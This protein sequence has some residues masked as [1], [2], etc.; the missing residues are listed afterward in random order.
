MLTLK[1]IARI[2]HEANRAV[3]QN[4]GDDSQPIWDAAPEW[5][6]VSAE[7]G[8]KKVRDNPSITPEQL[9]QAW[10]DFKIADGWT[11]GDVKDAN[12]KAHPCLVPYDK[13]PE[14]QR[15]KDVVFRAICSALI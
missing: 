13:L 7:E 10:C 1:E 14:S 3:C 2:C 8:V 5:Q 11:Y 4:N 12:A 9:H 15:T 6:R